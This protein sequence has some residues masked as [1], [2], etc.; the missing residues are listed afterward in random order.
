MKTMKTQFNA[1]IASILLVVLICGC[2][3][4]QNEIKSPVAPQ[5]TSEAAPSTV[6]QT[7][8][9]STTSESEQKFLTYDDP[10]GGIRIKYS[11]DWYISDNSTVL[12]K[13]SN[14]E[15][16]EEHIVAGAYFV[17]KF[18]GPDKQYER[19]FIQ[20]NDR[21]AEHMT[22]EAYTN[23]RLS[24]EKNDT[25]FEILESSD[26]TLSSSPAYRMVR[27][28]K[29]YGSKDMCIWTV[30]NNKSYLIVFA[31]DEDIY[32]KDIEMVNEMVDSFTITK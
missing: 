22:L 13:K 18:E 6:S 25:H 31:A 29:E 28:S 16:P 27:A 11:K 5:T 4:N 10:E 7:I 8:T 21:S 23:M 30:M 1:V 12:V 20:V 15:R 9:G 2:T 26:Y 24:L 32:S 19:F 17:P 3:Q 14:E